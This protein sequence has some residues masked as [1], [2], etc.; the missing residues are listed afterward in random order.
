MNTVFISEQSGAV[1]DLI[2]EIEAY[3]NICMQK[4]P[5]TEFYIQSRKSNI[6]TQAKPRSCCKSCYMKTNGKIT[7]NAETVSYTLDIDD[8]S[9]IFESL[10]TEIDV[11]PDYKNSALQFIKTKANFHGTMHYLPERMGFDMLP[12]SSP[13]TGIYFILDSNDRIHKVGKA[14]GKGGLKRRFNNYRA[15]NCTRYHI[16]N[17]KTTIMVNRIMTGPLK[18]EILYMYV[19][20]IKKEPF[21]YEN[22]YTIEKSYIR[23][24]EEAIS[25]HARSDGHPM[26]LSS[27][28]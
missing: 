19:L 4:L 3:C 10:S 20:E 21:L 9:R 15:N 28:N 18:N 1:A 16:H 23:A 5:I 14:E 6:A 22:T 27:Q 8:D 12:Y 26:L 11:I 24:L 25:I 17:D 13:Q 2:G 7:K